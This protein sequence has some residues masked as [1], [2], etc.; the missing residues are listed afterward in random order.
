MKSLYVLRHGQAE[1]ESAAAGDHERELTRRGRADVAR[2]AGEL[3][4]RGNLPT[5]LLSS[6]A[7]RARQTAEGCVAAWPGSVTLTLTV[8]EELYLAEPVSYVAALAEQG[9]PHGAV[10]V[11]GHNPGLEA[12]VFAMTE[13]SEHLPTASLVALELAIDAWAELSLA[14]RGLGRQVYV[15]RP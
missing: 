9:E 12:L 10:M 15:F 11:V 4:Q 3:A 6:S 1:P 5:L 14:S 13:R 7:V 8:R 2:A